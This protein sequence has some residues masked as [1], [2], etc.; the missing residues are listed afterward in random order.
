MYRNLIIA[1]VSSST[2]LWAGN[3]LQEPKRLIQTKCKVSATKDGVSVVFS[4]TGANDKAA[5]KAARDEA[6]KWGADPDDIS[7]CYGCTPVIE[8]VAAARE[9]AEKSKT[10]KAVMDCKISC[11]TKDTNKALSSQAETEQAAWNNLVVIA[12]PGGG[13]APA[14]I[15]VEYVPRFVLRATG[16]VICRD[17]TNK[18]F[19]DYAVSGTDTL[20]LSE[21]V[22]LSAVDT[23][24]SR[25]EE[26]AAARGLRCTREIAPG[27]QKIQAVFAP[28]TTVAVQVETKAGWTVYVTRR[29][30]LK[31]TAL[32]EAVQRAKD[33]ANTFGGPVKDPYEI[34][35]NTVK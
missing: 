16:S 5:C 3:T 11:V 18:E 29:A 12:K 32:N 4:G 31:S 1:L 15:K 30:F 22:A 27:V 6:L 17:N 19:T 21:R 35:V 23:N 13:V 14:S 26:A 34:E 25:V 2:L 28:E 10:A 24:A 20:G 7:D 33:I 8:F 9:A